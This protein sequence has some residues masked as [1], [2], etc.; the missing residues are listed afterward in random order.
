[1]PCRFWKFLVKY[2][3]S[4]I[5][6]SDVG[7]CSFAVLQYVPM[8]ETRYVFASQAAGRNAKAGRLG[9]PTALPCAFLQPSMSDRSSS[10]LA[11]VPTIAKS[12]WQALITQLEVALGS[13]L[14]S[15]KSTT[16]LRPARP[17]LALTSFAHA[18][19]AFTESWNRPGTS[20]LFTSASMATRMVVAVSPMSL[21]GA[22][23]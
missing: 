12:F 22:A 1:M 15:Q 4:P 17:P 10:A 6:T 3:A 18:L 7:G 11:D 2:R 21:P 14:E 19:T 8:P 23:E 9:M 20:G 5:G 16:T 13:S